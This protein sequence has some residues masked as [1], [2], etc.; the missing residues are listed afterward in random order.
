VLPRLAQTDFD[1]LL[2]SC[3]LNFVRG[4]DSLVRAIWAGA[5]FVW[6]LY[7]QDDGAHRAKLDAFLDRFLAG[8]PASLQTAVRSTSAC[9]NDVAEG[10]LAPLSG[11]PALHAAWS[12]QCLRWRDALGAQT[13]LATRLIAFVE[14]KR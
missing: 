12:A 9:W 3:E 10:S 8:A 13:D 4:E 6:Q 1:R 14:A 11:D 5:P 7:V 2:W